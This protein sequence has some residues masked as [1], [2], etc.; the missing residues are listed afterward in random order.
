MKLALSWLQAASH[1]DTACAAAVC[2]PPEFARQLAPLQTPTPGA[3]APAGRLLPPHPAAALSADV[4][5]FGPAHDVG[6]KDNHVQLLNQDADSACGVYALRK[7]ATV[8]ILVIT[9][10]TT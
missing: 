1:E 2:H 7:C 4:L 6:C 8:M 10:K 9:T 5:Q 3:Q